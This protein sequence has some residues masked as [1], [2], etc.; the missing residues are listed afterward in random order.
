MCPACMATIALIAASATSAG[1]VTALAVN[2]LRAK[3]S[4]KQSDPTPQTGGEQDGLPQNCVA[5]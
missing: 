4:A 2:R 5:S 3:S 1:G